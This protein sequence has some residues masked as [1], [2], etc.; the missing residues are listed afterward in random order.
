MWIW[1]KLPP[2]RVVTADMTWNF[3]ENPCHIFYRDEMRIPVTVYLLTKSAKNDAQNKL[4]L[5]FPLISRD[6]SGR[7]IQALW[8]DYEND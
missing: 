1:T 3:H 6:S 5:N 7:S 8:E 2:S 4:C